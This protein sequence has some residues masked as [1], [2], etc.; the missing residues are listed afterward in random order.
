MQR[1]HGLRGSAGDLLGSQPCL[2]SRRQ[3]AYTPLPP[4]QRSALH[5]SPAAGRREDAWKRRP[6]K[7]CWVCERD[8]SDTQ[9]S[10]QPVAAIR[11]Q[12]PCPSQM[13]QPAIA[14]TS[15]RPSEPASALQCRTGLPTQ[16][17]MVVAGTGDE[18][19][20]LQVAERPDTSRNSDVDYLAVR[21][22][23][24]PP[25][26]TRPGAGSYLV[27]TLCYSGTVSTQPTEHRTVW[28][29][30]L[31]LGVPFGLLRVAQ[32]VSGSYAVAPGAH[33]VRGT[34]A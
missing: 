21:L 3:L 13:G 4:G 31:R 5:R 32:D 16:G 30:T 25:C 17:D 24:A 14:S 18:F 27:T 20:G 2:T 28:S 11:E 15:R 19:A 22:C 23:P 26:P 6:R 12:L 7:G 34:V 8:S 1:L 9:R 10:Q 33:P 29:A